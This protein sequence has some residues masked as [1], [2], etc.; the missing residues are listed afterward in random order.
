MYMLYH[1]TTCSQTPTEW[2]CREEEWTRSINN[3]ALLTTA[4]A[5]QRYWTN[6][7]IAAVYLMNRMPSRMLN[8]E[9]P[10]QALD[11]HVPLPSF[12]MI[13]PRIFGCVAYVHLH[14]NQRSKLD[15][16]AVRCIFLGYAAHKKGYRCYDPTTRRLYVTMDV[17]C[18]ENEFFFQAPC[19]FSSLQGSCLMKS[20]TEAMG[21]I[22]H[23]L[24]TQA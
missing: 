22:G 23:I 19:S 5:P 13:P 14:K 8:F 1:E 20:R 4:H 12:L 21:K 3:R 10:L 16:C 9:T 15:P 18:L 17:T 2:C 11:H 6:A 7:V 24:Q